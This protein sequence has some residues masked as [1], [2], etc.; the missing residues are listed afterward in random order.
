MYSLWDKL[1]QRQKKDRKDK[2][3]I[4]LQNFLIKELNN[5][6]K[7]DD[8]KIQNLVFVR[9]V[10]LNIGSILCEQCFLQTKHNI[11]YQYS[12][13]LIKILEDVFQFLDQILSCFQN[14]LQFQEEKPYHQLRIFYLMKEAFDYK[15]LKKDN[16]WKINI[17]ILEIESH[18]FFSTQYALNHFGKDHYQ[19]INK[20]YINKFIQNI[21]TSQI[22]I[23]PYRQ[24]INLLPKVINLKKFHPQSDFIYQNT[25]SQNFIA[26]LMSYQIIIYNIRTDVKFDIIKVDY[27]NN[28]VQFFQF[29]KDENYLILAYNKPNCQL[30]Y[31]MKEKTTSIILDQQI[32]FIECI[33]Y[34]NQ[35][36]LLLYDQ[37]LR[38]IKYLEL[39]SLV[40]KDFKIYK[41][42]SNEIKFIE[43]FT[44]YDQIEKKWK[45]IMKNSH[46]SI[47]TQKVQI[48]KKFK[49]QFSKGSR[50]NFLYYELISNSK[51]KIRRIYSTEQNQQYSYF[52]SQDE[53]FVIS[54]SLSFYE[55]STGKIT[56][57]FR[58]SEIEEVQDIQVEDKKIKVFSW[59]NLYIYDRIN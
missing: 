54:S 13:D 35:N 21:K 59:N 12:L 42:F 17:C 58:M 44:F 40:H 15:S 5:N 19:N 23:N 26:I 34:N 30:V 31:N 11:N 50:M 41:L 33:Q 46:G 36:C 6:H 20:A 49:L 55:I 24:Y 14:D 8:H 28:N 22:K 43:G 1:K 16:L 37:N 48:T 39:Q 3:T 25:I 9:D 45:N 18:L 27:V 2:R 47:I 10:Q 56:F 51:K 52:L 57:E 32:S 7:I 29:T 53:R 38:T 4:M